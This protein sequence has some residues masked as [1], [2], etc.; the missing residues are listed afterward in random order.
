MAAPP[1]GRT[2]MPSAYDP[3]AVEQRLYEFWEGNGY[4][5]A[6][7]E[8]GKP[9]FTI[10]MPPPNVTGELHLG[11]ALTAAVE[12][13]LIR[14]HRMLGDPTLWLPGTDHAG[15]A[16][17]MVVEREIAKEGLTRHDLGR[18]EFVA[19]V[20]QW[21]RRYRRRID[22]QHRRLGASCDWSR[23][24]F[25]M[26]ETP[27]LAVRTTFKRLYD[28]GL[29]YRGERMINWCPRCMTAL[30]D[31]E[32]DRGDPEPG[33]LWHLR[34]PLLD[35]EGRETGEEL[36]M[37][38]TRPETMVADTAVAVNPNDARY[39]H[40]IGR[41]VRLPYIGREIP[42]IG[43]EAVDMTFGTGV[44]KVTPGHD[45]TD[46]EIGRRHS[47]PII[48]AMNLDGTMNAEA[49]DLAGLDRFDAR[50]EL[51]KIFE[52]DGTLVKTEPHELV[53]GRCDR[54]DTI[55]EPLV[56]LQWFVST[57]P[58][59]EPAMQVVRDGRIR[60]VPESFEKVYFTWME[61]I[62]DWCISRQLWWGHRIP[63]WYCAN[64]HTVVA[65]EDPPACPECGGGLSQDEDVLDTWF[66]SGLWTHSTL[67]WP[68]DTEDLRTFYPTTVME[69]GYDILFFWVA[70]MIMLGLFNMN[71]VEPFRW[72][73][74][75]GLVRDA[76]GRKMS[77]TR[78][79]TVDPL[80]LVERYG[81]DALRFMLVTGSSPGNDMKLTDSDLENA[82]NFA[83]KL[84]NTARFVLRN[85]GE[86]LTPGPSPNAGRGE[87]P[88]AAVDTL[89]LAQHWERGSGGEG[90]LEDRWIISRLNTLI[91]D[92]NRFAG[93]FQLG[94]AAQHIYDFVW[95]EYAD[96][97]IEMAKV[98]LARGDRSPLPVLLDVLAASLRLLH[99]YMP[100]V[101]EEI[102][103]NLRPYLGA[104]AAPALIVAPY[105]LPGS[106]GV[107]PADAA[108]ERR[109]GVLI[110]IVRAARNLRAERRLPPG[111][112]VA[113]QLAVTD[114]ET[115]AALEDR[116]ELIESLARLRP[117]H[118][119][120]G[121][122]D[123]PREGVA[124]AVL[125]DAT[126]ALHLPGSAGVSAA[127]AA[128]ERARLEKEIVETEAYAGRLA[129]QLG[130]EAFRTR[131][132]EKV[133]RTIEENLAAAQ[134]RLTGLR[135]SLKD[136]GG[137]MN[138]E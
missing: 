122:G 70:R 30:S 47:L 117:L 130:N 125:A 91:A 69:T 49:K 129:R 134:A 71:G 59:A 22:D 88:S 73:Y 68:H 17:Q 127:S 137:R 11:H 20:W 136:E 97:Y 80:E 128:A 124:T 81:A 32:V 52:G 43:D 1:S 123:V 33:Y 56:S 74:L 24:R 78:G 90:R 103:Q 108:A 5:Q 115:R 98:R 116:I 48:T 19:R 46:Y 93:E 89:P 16:T 82:R 61:N 29:I 51:I 57:K 3:R 26:D 105:P 111:Q 42:V 135:R 133:V 99:P 34:Y 60:I 86:A 45:P 15:I 65:I 58:L 28:A 114:A 112:F 4:F 132:P 92:V 72:V 101:T 6:H 18:E 138:E 84:W 87:T 53:I 113:A 27:A 118:I 85:V 106:A 41:M 109:T 54:C 121:A 31:L 131:A 63:V 126:L 94:A 40:L 39:A 102:W 67:G 62:R 110:D 25:T 64:G 100:F 66:S 14:W 119:V 120:A 75:H 38:T 9:A 12:D 107:S 50:A 23:N 55:V 83:N 79:N 95:H 2:E 35:D 77:K 21:V 76:Q 44:V 36:Q 13:A 104:E 37:A 8:P 10:I 7:I 96:W